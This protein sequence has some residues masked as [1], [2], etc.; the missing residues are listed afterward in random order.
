MALC[1]ACGV[2]LED[3][4][5]LRVHYKSELHRVN[6][7]RRSRDLPPVTAE[8]YERYEGAVAAAK[9][10]E[11]AAAVSY[12]YVCDACNKRFA[13]SGQFETHIRTKKHVARV[14]EL[15]A[16]RDSGGAAAGAGAS[17]PAPPSAAPTAA[18][19]AGGG[20]AAAAAAAAATP[21]TTPTS[22]GGGG[23]GAAGA[24]AAAAGGDDDDSDGVEADGVATSTDKVLVVTASHCLF[25]F[26]ASDNVVE[27]VLLRCCCLPPLFPPTSP[28]STPLPPATQ[29]PDAH[30]RGAQL[31]LGRL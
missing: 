12:M 31:F 2:R 5:T 19:S 14:K 26:H 28:V 21:S 18:P 16:A 13:S 25:C 1:N 20:A 6:T 17:A 4:E 29:E 10:E 23:G 3:E 15:L 9:A 11:E 30:A 22:G 24:A 8:A 27:Y 7:G